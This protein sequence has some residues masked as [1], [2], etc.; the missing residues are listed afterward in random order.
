VADQAATAET[1]SNTAPV[2]GLV[3]MIHVAD[4]E[5]SVEFYRRLGFE[6]GNYVPRVENC[7]MA[8]AWLYQP[9]APDWKTGANLMLTVSHEEVKPGAH[10][11]LFY[12][13]AANLVEVR[14]QLLAQGMKVG[15]IC[16]PE[17]LPEGEFKTS[18]PD[19][20]TLMIAQAGKDT[21]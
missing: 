3:P 9:K 1:S 11:V 7:P 16:F 6:V 21:P 13:Y 20:Y 15:E 4:V 10:S 12:L 14:N 2:R 5:R 17:Y 18:D 19:G 8:W